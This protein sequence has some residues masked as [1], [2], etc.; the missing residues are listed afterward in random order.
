METATLPLPLHQARLRLRLVALLVILLFGIAGLRLLFIA[1][2]HPATDIE[3]H[4]PTAPPIYVPKRADL[5]DRNGMLLATNLTTHSVYANPSKLMDPVEVAHQIAAIFPEQDVGQLIGKLGDRKR[6]F[7][8]LHR[9]LT[10]AQAQAVNALGQPGIEFVMD[11]RRVY[12]NGRMAGQILGYTDVDGRGLTGLEKGLDAR[13]HNDPNTPVR[14][15]LDLR[16]Q[17]LLTTEL[18][19]NIAEFSA[20]GGAAM[21]MDAKTSEIL[22][23]VSLPDF[24]PNDPMG[25]T[26]DQKFNRLTLG[27]YE[28]GS[29]MK[30]FSTANALEA[31]VTSLQGHYDVR[32]PIKVGRFTINDFKGK[33]RILTTAEVFKYSSNIGSAHM[34]LQVGSVRQQAFLHKLGLLAPPHLELPEMG[35]PLIPHPWREVSTMTVAFGHGLSINA[36]QLVNA[37]AAVMNGGILRQPTLL[38]NGNAGLPGL[39]VIPESVSMDMRKLMRLTVTSGT[40][41]HADAAG[42]FVGGKTGTSEKPSA[43]GYQKKSLLSSFLALFPMYDPQYVVFVMVDEPKGTAKSGGYATGGWVAAPVVGRVV[44]R[45]GPL[46][47]L[48]AADPSDPAIQA[49]LAIPGETDVQTAQH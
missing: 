13:L 40:G 38:L 1:I 21:I 15:S 14:L 43:H 11:E 47:N 37:T 2:V 3:P 23:M 10:P 41:S 28:M 30:I 48:E 33:K 26:D 27:V 39:Q 34:G 46:L 24:N 20:I 31:G 32:F 45:M 4:R 5:L 19:R 25:A 44:A 8:W 18:E 6:Q 12:P 49:A 42:Y 36:V 22:A 29:T 7:V 16:L 17:H 9:N 35:R